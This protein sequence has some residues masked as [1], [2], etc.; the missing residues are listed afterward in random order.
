MA[1]NT[2]PNSA[3]Q[4][5][6]P[7]ITPILGVPHYVQRDRRLTNSFA[8][9][10]PFWACHT[11]AQQELRTTES[12]YQWAARGLVCM[13]F[14]CVSFAAHA[15]QPTDGPDTVV[16]AGKGGRGTSGGRA[17]YR[18]T[19]EDYNADELTLV[20]PGG[21]R[22]RF[23]VE[24][25]VEVHTAYGPSRQQADGLYDRK[26]YAAAAVLYGKALHEESR[27][28]ARRRIIQRMVRCY[29]AL[30][31]YARAGEAFL[32]LSRDDASAIDL[33]CMPLAWTPQRPSADLERAAGQWIARDDLPGAV[34]LGASHLLPVR[35]EVALVRLKYLAQGDGPFGPLARA[36]LW[37]A[38]DGVVSDGE[39]AAR[40]T[41]I[42]A[43]PGRLRGGPYYVLGRAQAARGQWDGAAL[44]WLRVPILHAG[45]RQLAAT[46]LF[47]AGHAMEKLG[48]T[49]E[50][51]IIYSELIQKHPRAAAA[52]EA[53]RRLKER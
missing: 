23:P 38:A 43:M 26:D 9:S 2:R 32:L 31:Q 33:G 52:G 20:L 36:Q 41:A 47:D 44:A 45:D 50:S 30:G 5:L 19:I 4:E 53:R 12:L 28:W 11:T 1:Q 35:R 13:A 3:Q 16:V 48:H 15:Q 39:L 22:R 34:L 7:P 27:R 40:E 21:G 37:R 46:A 42:E 51:D 8:P 29:R 49:E 10:R 24:R 6:R 25:I 17:T 18:G 14:F